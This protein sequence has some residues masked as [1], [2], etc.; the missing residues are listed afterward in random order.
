MELYTARLRLCL[1][2][3]NH[4]QAWE[5]HPSKLGQLLGAKIGDVFPVFPEEMM[6]ER[7]SNLLL[8]EAEQVWGAWFVITQSS[9]PM[10]IGTVGFHSPP[11]TEGTLEVGYSIVPGYRRQGYASEAVGALIAFALGTGFVQKVLATTLSQDAASGGVLKAN[12]FAQ[13]GP[14]VEVN[15]PDEG[16]LVVQS[17][18]RA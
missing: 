3:A 13:D 11:D 4:Y 10:V 5:E 8:P 15:D 1:K 2:S 14:A 16:L 18:V 7:A 9:N 6:V 17:W 12:G